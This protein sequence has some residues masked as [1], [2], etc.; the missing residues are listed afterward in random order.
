LWALII[1]LEFYYVDWT[2]LGEQEWTEG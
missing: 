1:L 2:I